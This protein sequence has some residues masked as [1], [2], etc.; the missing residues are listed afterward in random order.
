MFREFLRDHYEKTEE[1]SKKLSSE[2]KV[3]WDKDE[4]FR[5]AKLLDLIKD[6]KNKNAQ[7]ADI[8]NFIQETVNQL[9]KSGL[10]DLFTKAAEEYIKK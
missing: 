5:R 4:I 7:K 6:A 3:E 9:K 8:L 1:I 10:I 2:F